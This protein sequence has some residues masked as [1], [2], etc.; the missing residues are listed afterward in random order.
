MKSGEQTLSNLDSDNRQIKWTYTLNVFIN[1]FMWEQFLRGEFES[2]RVLKSSSDY[3][4]NIKNYYIY[5]IR[6]ISSIQ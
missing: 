1:I 3:F 2:G 5:V 6:M 4:E